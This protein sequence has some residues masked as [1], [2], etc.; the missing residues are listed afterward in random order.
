MK[1]KIRRFQIFNCQVCI[2]LVFIVKMKR[3]NR[4]QYNVLFLYQWTRLAWFLKGCLQK[5]SKTGLW[6]LCLFRDTEM[7][8]RTEQNRTE[9]YYKT[10]V[11]YDMTYEWKKEVCIDKYLHIYIS[12]QYRS[13][14]KKKEIN[15]WDKLRIDNSI[16]ER[17]VLENPN[18]T[19]DASL[20]HCTFLISI[21][22]NT[23]RSFKRPSSVQFV[24]SLYFSIFGFE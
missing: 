18:N 11:T 14:R 17:C 10:Q 16:T 4:I 8:R 6:H 22:A 24:N 5:E 9:L 20:C 23:Y 13:F 12:P 1:R 15:Y 7:V 3:A 21:L 19:I 2:F